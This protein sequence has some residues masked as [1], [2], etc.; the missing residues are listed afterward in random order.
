MAMQDE[1]AL[2]DGKVVEETVD[3]Q[4]FKLAVREVKQCLQITGDSLE[5]ICSDIES[6]TSRALIKPVFRRLNN[7]AQIFLRLAPAREYD[8]L[9]TGAL[10]DLEASPRLQTFF[11]FCCLCSRCYIC[12]QIFGA[13]GLSRHYYSRSGIY[14]DLR[15]EG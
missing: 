7:M 5:K 2:V 9:I 8:A 1:V 12:L 4:V 15:P 14:A 3:P 10:C 13:E 11:K 6:A